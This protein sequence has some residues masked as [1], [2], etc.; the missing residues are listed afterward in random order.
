MAHRLLADCD[1][2]VQ[3]TRAPAFGRVT[4]FCCATLGSRQ[5]ACVRIRPILLRPI[6]LKHSFSA[7]LEKIAFAGDVLLRRSGG[8]SDIQST[9]CRSNKKK[10]VIIGHY[11][12]MPGSLATPILGHLGL[13]TLSLDPAGR[14]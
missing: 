10:Y 6:L 11:R 7:V 13:T 12:R 2:E 4:T 1:V 5:E 3:S 9:P 8:R 14:S